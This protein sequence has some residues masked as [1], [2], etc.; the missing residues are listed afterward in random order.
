MD[1]APVVRG[2]GFVDDDHFI[3]VV[4]ADVAVGG[5]KANAVDDKLG[6]AEVQFDAVTCV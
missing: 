3:C 4:E 1:I 6:V 5:F 2:V